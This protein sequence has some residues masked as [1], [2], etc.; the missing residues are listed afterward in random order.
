MLTIAEDVDAIYKSKKAKITAAQEARLK[1]AQKAQAAKEARE[2]KEVA[3]EAAKEAAKLAKTLAA[4]EV[5]EEKKKEIVVSPV[6]DRE[7]T[8]VKKEEKKKDSSTNK[9]AEK[10]TP[11]KPDPENDET[12]SSSTKRRYTAADIHDSDF[13]FT[14]DEDDYKTPQK[15]AKTNKTDSASKQN[16][17]VT[18]AKSDA[19][20]SS[21]GPLAKSNPTSSEK[22]ASKKRLSEVEPVASETQRPIAKRVLK[23]DD[24]ED[25]N[26][27]QLKKSAAVD[28]EVV[29]STTNPTTSDNKL[30]EADEGGTP[31][32]GSDKLH[33]REAH[34]CSYCKG[35][36][37]SM[38]CMNRGH[39]DG[40]L[41]NDAPHKPRT[42]M[43]AA[44]CSICNSLSKKRYCNNRSH[45]EGELVMVPVITKPTETDTSHAKSPTISVIGTCSFCKTLQKRLNCNN[46]E[47]R[48]GEMV[49]TIKNVESANNNHDSSATVPS[50][51]VSRFNSISYEEEDDDEDVDGSSKLRLAEERER[52]RYYRTHH[53]DHFNKLNNEKSPRE[54]EMKSINQNNM[55]VTFISSST[56]SFAPPPPHDRNL[57]PKKSVLKKESS[58]PAMSAD[59]ILLQ[60]ESAL[61]S[62]SSD[63]PGVKW[64]D[65]EGRSNLREIFTF[66]ET[67]TSYL[68]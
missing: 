41:V 1:A 7:I 68:H 31:R 50:P 24:E 45:R 51:R 34:M 37:K 39:I 13:E 18:K 44:F 26:V 65:M 60:L 61:V 25:Q 63:K 38:R 4:K 56:R 42:P 23:D 46:K 5:K 16:S 8:P 62:T 12:K 6:P 17:S 48:D 2:A 53:V 36:K 19:T 64:K 3:K 11:A 15:K 27:V 22:S 9:S 35:V 54:K 29:S 20:P 30:D 66:E 28:D 21:E 43:T 49:L 40:Y 10:V 14:S 33:K 59:P 47:H 55:K 57:Q 58:L 52:E 32:N 67:E